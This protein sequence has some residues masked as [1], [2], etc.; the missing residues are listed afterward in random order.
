VWA[1]RLP[2]GGVID[3][4][5]SI[6]SYSCGSTMISDTKVEQAAVVTS[7]ETMYRTIYTSA[8][9]AKVMITRQTDNL[10]KC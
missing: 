2:A 9:E 10:G 6:S 4:H 8:K 7:N 3:I 1:T 5:P